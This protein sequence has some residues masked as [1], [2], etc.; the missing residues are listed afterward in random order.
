MVS[1][2]CQLCGSSEH[3]A[4]DDDC[5]AFTSRYPADDVS[6]EDGYLLWAPVDEPVSSSTEGRTVDI[7]VSYGGYGAA[8]NKTFDNAA[9]AAAFCRDRKAA[10]DMFSIWGKDSDYVWWE[11]RDLLSPE[12][13]A[14]IFPNGQ[15]GSVAT[16]NEPEKC[17]FCGSP[18]HGSFS[19]D[20]PAINDASGP[21]ATYDE[22][23][24][25]ALW[26]SHGS[27][28]F[29]CPDCSRLYFSDVLPSNQLRT[30]DVTCTCGCLCHGIVDGPG[31]ATGYRNEPIADDEPAIDF[32][33]SSCGHKWTDPDRPVDGLVSVYFCPECSSSVTFGG[34]DHSPYVVT[35]DGGG[36][37]P[38]DDELIVTLIGDR[39]HYANGDRDSYLGWRSVTASGYIRHEWRD[40]LGQLLCWL[41]IKPA[42]V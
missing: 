35:T 16:D 40:S 32:Q 10:G 15:P 7:L 5:Q 29:R 34:D 19:D 12:H 27:Y 33:C 38:A 1:K 4:Y 37:Y 18:D 11:L 13:A 3:A 39:N 41:V 6:P 42:T 26:V 30:Y 20:C 14:E 21:V 28:G 2:P 36:T 8:K 9:D 25:D 24:L 31:T 22:P 23:A 17:S